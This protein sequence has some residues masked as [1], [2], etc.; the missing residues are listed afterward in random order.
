MPR[1][2][3]VAW[4]VL[5]DHT[6]REYHLTP[7]GWVCETFRVYGAPT[8]KMKPP[9]DRVETWIEEM[10][11]HP[12]VLSPRCSGANLGIRFRKT[13]DQSRIEPQVSSI[14]PGEAEKNR[15]I[16]RERWNVKRA[17]RS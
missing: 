8:Q 6:E 7:V 5:E 2:G 17:K 13:R 9:P 10:T 3:G 15:R 14:Q 12:A 1:Q 16:G 4:K 11:T